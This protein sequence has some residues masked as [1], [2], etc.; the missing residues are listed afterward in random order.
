M[1]AFVSAPL[2]SSPTIPAS[3][4]A[5]SLE[6]NEIGVDGASALAAVLKETQITNLGCAAALSEV[7]VSL[8]QR[9]LTLLSTCFLTRAR[10]LGG[11]QLGPEG[12]A[13]L[14]EGLKGNSKLQVL[15]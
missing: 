2:D 10:R 11:N 14:A 6:Y 1:F 9:P 8:C 12:G 5:R 4:L 15:E 13:A 7:R 3:P